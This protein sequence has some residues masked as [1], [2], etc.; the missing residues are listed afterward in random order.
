MILYGNRHVWDHLIQDFDPSKANYGDVEDHP[1]LVDINFGS[2]SSDWLHSNSIDYN[3][4][5]DQILLSVHN[6]HEIWI[7]DHSTTTEEA[8]GHTG[9]NSGK[10]GDIRIP[11][12]KS[13][14]ISCR[15]Y[16]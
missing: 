8:A 15:G 5:F 6:F 9:G 14:S 2:Y 13:K 7:I 3:E 1:E 12:G 11:L 4:E 16:E 10:G